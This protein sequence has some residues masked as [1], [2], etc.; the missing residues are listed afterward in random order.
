[1]QRVKSELSRA[2]CAEDV[3]KVAL[4]AKRMNANTI[5]MGLLAIQKFMHISGIQEWGKSVGWHCLLKQAETELPSFSTI[6]FLKSLWAFAKLPYQPEGGLLEAM[7]K[8]SSK[9]IPELVDYKSIAKFEYAMRTMHMASTETMDLLTRQ[10]EGVIGDLNKQSIDIYEG[11]AALAKHTIKAELSALKAQSV[12]MIEDAAGESSVARVFEEV[13]MQVTH[14]HRFC[15]GTTT[16]RVWP[17][18]NENSD[19]M[20]DGGENDEQSW[21]YDAC[22]MQAPVGAD[23][24][25]M[26]IHAAGARLRPG[27]MIFCW[28]SRW[29]YLT[30][31][32]KFVQ[33]GAVGASL[34]L[35]GSYKLLGESEVGCVVRAEATG[36]GAGGGDSKHRA[37]FSAW[38]SKA[39]MKLKLQ[40]ISTSEG[41]EEGVDMNL[42]WRV[43]P[44][45]FAGGMCNIMTTGATI[46]LTA[47]CLASI[48]T[49]VPS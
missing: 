43:Y 18:R 35:F 46:R 2:K 24:F 22:C 17:P 1:M 42:K 34:S 23:A 26:A 20:S 31:Q 21:L 41:E 47:P 28:G 15:Q 27:G 45:L 13:G 5:C 30:Q 40:H 25:E 48:L 29:P 33:S 32:P 11:T 8:Y 38:R 16:G 6:Q 14:W 39:K 10:A 36:H 49:T 19:Q 44:G 12:L 4:S 7:K 3:L 9:A 37:Q